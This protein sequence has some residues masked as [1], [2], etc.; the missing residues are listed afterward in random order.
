MDTNK[1][2]LIA[3]FS[4]SG[5]TRRLAHTLAETTGGQLHE[6]QPVQAYTASDLDWNDKSSRSSL[7][8]ADPACRPAIQNKVA[9][10]DQYDL[11]FL[12]FPIWWYEAP[13]IIA[14]F[15]ESYDFTGKTVI[16]FAT[17]GGSGMGKTDSI[18]QK[19]CPAPRWLPGA[20][21]SPQASQDQLRTWIEQLGC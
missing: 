20:R 4:C 1:K 13:R 10:M 11:V 17:S 5:Q 21:L 9:Q 15:L 18:L 3:Y 6:I 12:G 19:I 7:E 8:M 14:T 2:P 16:P